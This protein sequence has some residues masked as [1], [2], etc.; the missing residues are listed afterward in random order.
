ML[1]IILIYWDMTLSGEEYPH[2]FMG[3]NYCEAKGGKVENCKCNYKPNAGKMI[4]KQ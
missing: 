3:Y 1:V 4:W 2:C